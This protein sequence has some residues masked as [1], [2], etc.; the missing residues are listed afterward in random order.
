MAPGI[1]TARGAPLL[2]CPP[3]GP[4]LSRA[5]PAWAGLPAGAPKARPLKPFVKKVVTSQWAQSVRRWVAFVT[6]GYTASGKRV[7]KRARGR[8]KIEA[9]HKLKEIMRDYEDGLTTAGHGYT[10]ADAV[11]DWL[12]FGLSGRDSATVEKCTILPIRT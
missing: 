12:A 11:R 8:T 2:V 3:A 5:C 10:V 1:I 6:V 9:K 7:F 4:G